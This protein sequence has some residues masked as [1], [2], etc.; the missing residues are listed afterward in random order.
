MLLVIDTDVEAKLLHGV[1]AFLVAA[2]DPGT[3][4]AGA[5]GAA[6][7]RGLPATALRPVDRTITGKA[8][9]SRLARRTKGLALRSSTAP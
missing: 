1:V 4:T 3:A 9:T 5:A 8:A 2:G 6:S 7:V